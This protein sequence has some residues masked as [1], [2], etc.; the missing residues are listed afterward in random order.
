MSQYYT[1]W[2]RSIHSKQVS[3]SQESSGGSTLADHTQGK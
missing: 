2:L 3:T 1:R